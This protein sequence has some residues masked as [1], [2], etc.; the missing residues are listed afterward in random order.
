MRAIWEW[1]MRARWRTWLA[2][3]TVTFLL[4]VVGG[5]FVAFVAYAGRE[6]GQIEADLKKGGPI[7][8]LDHGLDAAV[9]FLVL[10]LTSAFFGW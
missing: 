6:I 4:A 7:D 9:P 5:G 8:W 2:H 10:V 1:T 3:G